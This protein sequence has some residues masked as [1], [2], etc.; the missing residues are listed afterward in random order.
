MM[1]F[2]K[3]RLKVP[4]ALLQRLDSAAAQA[5]ASRKDFLRQAIESELERI[6]LALTREEITLQEIRKNVL[7]EM[8]SRCIV[9]LFKLNDGV[10]V[11]G[12]MLITGLK[13]DNSFRAC[14]TKFPL[15]E[16]AKMARAILSATSTAV[17]TAIKST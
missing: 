9:V 11:C 5:G 8:T 16:S 1:R 3:I 17:F 2:K 4:L 12:S 7:A 15:C 6:E 10:P 14:T 13:E